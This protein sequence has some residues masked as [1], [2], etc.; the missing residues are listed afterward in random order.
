MIVVET[1]TLPASSVKELWD[2]HVAIWELLEKLEKLQIQKGK[3]N[4][5]LFAISNYW[6]KHSKQFLS[7]FSKLLQLRNDNLSV[8]ISILV[9][10]LV[11]PLG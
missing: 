9:T 6:I 5:V 11:G 7:S 4:F 8:T 2:E 10:H 3:L 1:S